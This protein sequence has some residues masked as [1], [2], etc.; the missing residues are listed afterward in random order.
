MKAGKDMPW[1]SHLAFPLHSWRVDILYYPF[2]SYNLSAESAEWPSYES[3][4]S[5]YLV[6]LCAGFFL[7][8]EHFNATLNPTRSLRAAAGTWL[9]ITVSFS[10]LGVSALSEVYYIH[11]WIMELFPLK[12]PLSST[13]CSSNVTGWSFRINS[14][15]DFTKEVTFFS[16]IMHIFLWCYT[17][18][19]WSSS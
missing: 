16:H 3:I 4:S 19:S 11:F 12:V 7:S 10:Q 8:S 5:W 13:P 14:S 18:G 15:N 17:L 1:F 9:A 2:S 6:F